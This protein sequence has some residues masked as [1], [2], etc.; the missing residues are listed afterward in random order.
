MFVS[1][2]GKHGH[3]KAS[4]HWKKTHS[5]SKQLRYYAH[6]SKIYHLNLTVLE[7]VKIQDLVV[8]LLFEN[9]GVPNLIM[10]DQTD[11]LRNG[12]NESDENRSLRFARGLDA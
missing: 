5:S 3:T 1:F 10:V 4:N 12:T 11:S 7:I 6:F 8:R 2:Y 9:F